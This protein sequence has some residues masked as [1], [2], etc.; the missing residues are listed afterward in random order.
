MGEIG[1]GLV[2][3]VGIHRDDTEKDV[4]AMVKKMLSV[5]LFSKEADDGRWT[6]SV[7]TMGLPVLLVSQF[8]LYATFKVRITAIALGTALTWNQ[9]EKADFQPKHGAGGGS[10]AF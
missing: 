5:N 6:E 8:T 3:L 10:C 2:V 9:G 7:E 1:R 4:A